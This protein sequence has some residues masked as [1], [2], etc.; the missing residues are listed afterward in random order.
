[1]PLLVEE[2]PKTVLESGLLTEPG[3]HYALAGPLMPL[4]IPA[5]G[6]PLPPRPAQIAAVIR[7]HLPTKVL[8]AV[9]PLGKDELRTALD[10]Q[11]NLIF[12]RRA[13]PDAAYTFKLTLV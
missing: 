12:R 8:A 6:A 10:Q 11:S 13:P 3:G 9:S 7:G 5:I 1:M 4:A 2:L